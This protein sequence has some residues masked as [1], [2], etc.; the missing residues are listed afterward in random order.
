MTYGSRFNLFFKTDT[1]KT[2]QE[3]IEVLKQYSTGDILT[4]LRNIEESPREFDE[5]IIKS[6]YSC[7][8]DKGIMCI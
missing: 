8:F 5:E 1:E 2:N 4:L 3:K 6:V 7:L